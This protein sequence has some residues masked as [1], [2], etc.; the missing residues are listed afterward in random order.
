MGVTKKFP[1]IVSIELFQ[2]LVYTF[3]LRDRFEDLSD[4]DA[5]STTSMYH[6]QLLGRKEIT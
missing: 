6:K 2:R 3:D 5:T 1:R 4:S